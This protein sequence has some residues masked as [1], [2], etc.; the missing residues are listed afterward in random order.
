MAV[1][2][3]PQSRAILCGFLDIHRRMAELEALISPGERPSSFS[4]YVDDLSPTEAKVVQDHFA[5]I[6]TAMLGHL[7]DLDIPLDIRRVSLRWSLQTGISFIGNTVDELRPSKLR[8]YGELN[9]E[10]SAQCTKIN[11]DLGRLLDRVAAYLR[12]GIGRDLQERLSRLDNAPV[13]VSTISQLEKIVERWQL[14]EFRPALE[15][16]VSRLESPSFEIAVFGRVSSGKSSFLNQIAGVDALPVGVT[17][18]TAVPTRMVSGDKPSVVVSFA[19]SQSHSVGLEHVWEY[20]SEEGNPGNQ[21][22][23]TRILVKLP[24]PRL[25]EGIVFVDTPGV[26]SLALAGGAETNAYLPRCDLGVVLVD[27]V[28]T[29]NQE[30][31]ALLR[32]LYGAGIPATLLLSKADLLT[33]GDRVRMT[34]YVREQI[35]RELRLDL[36]VHPVSTVGTDESLLTAWFEKELTPLLDR[37]R[38]LAEASLERKIA[39]LR[40]SIIAVLEMIL[41]KQ[42]G[43]RADDQTSVDTTTA[44]QLLDEADE[45][46]RRARECSLNWWEVRRVLVD[47]IPR[48]VAEKVV[49]ARGPADESDFAGVIEQT[50]FRRGR[51]AH[52]LIAGLQDTLARTL[53]RLSRVAPLAHADPSSIRGFHAGGLPAVNLDGVRREKS[54]L[55]PWWTGLAPPLA[56]RVTERVIEERYGKAMNDAVEFYD[57]QLESWVKAKLARLV[58]LYEMQ[59]GA[60]RE[61]I[62]RLA[63]ESADT[64]RAGGEGDLEA[65]LRELR[66]AGNEVKVVPGRPDLLHAASG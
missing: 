2:N 44:Q 53:E 6:R 43:S 23:V 59:A 52:D 31:L 19:E 29:L 16:I 14:V 57:R 33:I 60:F 46:I 32:A 41:A 12:E 25:R 9:Q 50:L 26:G 55:R 8:G 24:S 58:E 18:V 51:A 63:M 15:M 54:G 45:A 20:A 13:G 5:R 62:R 34:D 39:H 11:E 61:Q 47:M 65:D 17:P 28:S 35:R 38:S 37:H 21:K 1:L 7:K 22:H 36:P 3:E 48:L 56:T 10:A 42:R 64:G 30:D 40:E 66:G 27:A 4:G 49:S